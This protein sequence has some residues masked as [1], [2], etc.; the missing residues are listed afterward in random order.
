MSKW[1]LSE[2]TLFL[3]VC[4]AIG[5]AIPRPWSIF[6]GMAWGLIADGVFKLLKR[7]ALR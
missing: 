2:W 3:S 5:L 1:K 6:G 4:V 7:G